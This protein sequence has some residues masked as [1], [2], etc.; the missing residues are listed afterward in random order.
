MVELLNNKIIISDIGSSLLTNPNGRAIII[1][2][3]SL[4]NFLKSNFIK[5]Y[6]NL[7]LKELTIE[8]IDMYLDI[9]ND[10][11]LNEKI[12]I[13]KTINIDLKD[14]NNIKKQLEDDFYSKDILNLN[15]KD[16]ISFDEVQKDEFYEVNGL[17]DYFCLGYPLL[18]LD[19]LNNL[20]DINQI[21]L[22][23]WNL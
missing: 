17:E 23:D 16:I 9:I 10:L 12:D 5:N 8:N 19:I 11:N 13:L 4:Q 1:N 14:M 18:T 2:V 3:D 22:L 6:I 15:L 20:S 21:V 7:N